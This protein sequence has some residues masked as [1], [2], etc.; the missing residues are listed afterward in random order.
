[1]PLN[2]GM[3]IK[4]TTLF[5]ITKTNRNSRRGMLDDNE[6]GSMKER[7]QQS[8]LE[9]LLQVV[10]LRSQ[11]EEVTTPKLSVVDG[12]LWGRKGKLNQWSFT[13]NIGY[14]S[15]Y[16]KDGDSLGNLKDDCNG[17]PMVTGLDESVDIGNTLSIGGATSNIRFEVQD[18]T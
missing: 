2:S 12:K 11:P 8:N 16:I 6:S 13:F 9:T 17:V 14:P 10:G 3:K 15:I 1:M 7:N 5:D 4:C 18:D